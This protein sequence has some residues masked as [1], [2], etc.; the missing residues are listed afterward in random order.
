MNTG[1]RRAGAI[2]R[3]QAAL[4]IGSCASTCGLPTAF[5]QPLPARSF[6]ACLAEVANRGRPPASF[7]NELVDWGAT[8]DA[9]IFAP[10]TANDVYASV[11]RELGP[12]EGDR[13][14]RA[15]MLE[16]LRV[17]AGFESSWNWNEGVDKS[18][19]VAN[20][21]CNEEAGIFQVSAD[22]MSYSA[23]L[24]DLARTAG[25]DTTCDTFRRTTKTNHRFAMEYCARMLRITTAHNGPIRGRHIHSWLR[26]EAV[27]EFQQWL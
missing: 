20:T 14:R 4:W 13:H 25:G 1:R 27:A 16:V 3:R 19:S 15:V 18:K 6:D 17:L 10:N 8:A 21:A 7:L 22:S 24:R 5:A 11:A 26:R 23:A 12:W 2:T 9:A